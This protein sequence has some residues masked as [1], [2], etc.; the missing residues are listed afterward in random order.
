MDANSGK[1]WSEMDIADGV[2]TAL[3]RIYAGR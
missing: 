2:V 3:S 1:P